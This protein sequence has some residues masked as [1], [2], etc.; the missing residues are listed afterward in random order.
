MAAAE[1]PSDH[2]DDS[3]CVRRNDR[4]SSPA[5][6]AWAR[7]AQIV[8]SF[9]PFLDLNGIPHWV[10]LALFTV[11][12]QFAFGAA[13][14]PFG[15][16]P[17][18]HFLIPPVS[19]KEFNLG[20]GSVWFLANWLQAAL[21]SGAFTGVS[22]T[23]GTLLS[24]ETMTLESGVYV[25]PANATLTVT[26]N[27]TATLPPTATGNPGADAAA[28]VFTPPPTVALIFKQSS[29]AFQFVDSASA[30]AYG[31]SV[32]LQWNK[33][34]V[35]ASP[36]LPEIVVP[37]NASP[38]SFVFKN[39]SSEIFTPSGGAS[40]V[41]AGWALPLA[42]TSITTLPGIAGPG[43][44]VLELSGG[45][46]LQTV[47]QTVT[48]VL[49]WLVE[50]G[51][52]G[53]Y[54][55][56]KGHAAASDTTFQLWPEPAPSKLN[57]TVDFFT[58]PSFEYA[59]LSSS[60][61]ELLFTLGGVRAHLD[62]RPRR[63]PAAAR[64]PQLARFPYRFRRR[65]ACCSIRAQTG[66]TLFIVGARADER[67]VI[68]PLALENAL[69]GVDAPEAFTLVGALQGTQVGKCVAGFSFDLRWL[70]PMLPDPYAAN[71][72]L[73]L[74]REEADSASA[75]TVLA[76]T[77]WAGQSANPQLGFV[78][79]P[80][81]AAAE[82]TT[83]TPLPTVLPPSSSDAPVRRQPQVMDVALLDLSTRVDLLGVAVAPQIGALVGE[84]RGNI[85]SVG[86]I[87]ATTGSAT[88]PAPGVAF[89]GMWL[90]LNG[91]AVATFALPQ[92]SWEPME[93][94][95]VDQ[96]GPIVC[97]PAY[98]GF[99]LLVAAPNNQQ[100]IPFAPTQVLVNNVENVAAG[101]PFAALFS[102][103]FGLNAVDIQNNQ[104]SKKKTG[105]HSTFLLE[106]GRFGTNIPR[107]P[108]S[109]PPSPPVAAATCEA[110]GARPLLPKS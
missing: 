66:T 18:V 84:G 104:P 74:I 41:K 79:L 96:S 19:A 38:S 39:A 23:G 54:I 108:N 55:L 88:S 48:P 36:D 102:L 42:T 77:S 44:A 53:L 92:F 51:T 109:F 32:T 87:T 110:A 101:I 40:I 52:G 93:S 59:Y 56:A 60:T 3:E 57:A 91:A 1:P 37:F 65:R 24:S 106:G 34:E 78:L 9:G 73:S 20:S 82:D 43:A 80:P 33:G 97:D 71:F 72:N 2:R 99:P 107:F 83:A 50:I 49:D 105:F 61:D 47:L 86:S 70:L 85:K 103:P 10:D 15:L 58:N 100:L 90:A 21:P 30:V 13:S 26:L 76:E 14:T 28:A 12:T 29:A 7:G 22:I 69:I 98:D 25:V 81:A 6:P 27:L 5:A 17:I 75:G 94:T 64:A 95:A 16:F 89:S 11:S 63:P 67:K 45:S 46:S 62:R 8:Q 31:S 4:Q 68:V 35:V